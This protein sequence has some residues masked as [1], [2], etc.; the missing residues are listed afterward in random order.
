[1]INFIAI[2]FK[3]VEV[4]SVEL[5]ESFIDWFCQDQIKLYDNFNQPDTQDY[6]VSFVGIDSFIFDKLFKVKKKSPLLAK[7]HLVS[8][9]LNPRK[10]SDLEN[11]VLNV[12][13]KSLELTDSFERP[14]IYSGYLKHLSSP[15]FLPFHKSDII[16]SEKKEQFERYI[17]TGKKYSEAF[18]LVIGVKPFPVVIYIKAALD[19]P[20][21]LTEIIEKVTS[22]RS[23]KLKY[24]YPLISMTYLLNESLTT[25]TFALKV[26]DYKIL[27]LHKVMIF[28]YD[29]FESEGIIPYQAEFAYPIPMDVI[30]SAIED[31]MGTFSEDLTPTTEILDS[32]RLFRFDIEEIF[33]YPSYILEKRYDII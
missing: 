8:I 33:E 11:L 4:S 28:I 24:H 22:F 3:F 30:Q 26:F 31:M 9:F 18:P 27:P 29:L 17:Q 10:S 25:A 14:L 19:S 12:R 2:H 23:K 7:K 32:F 5:I 21:K 20:K 13:K 15:R 6:T 16:R 1:M